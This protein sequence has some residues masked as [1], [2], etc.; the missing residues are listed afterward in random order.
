MS[1]KTTQRCC[2]IGYLVQA[3][4]INFA[5]LLFVIFQNTYGISYALIGLLIFINF[6]TQLAAD[7]FS[8]PMLKFIGYRGSAVIS[9]LLCTAGFILLGI[10]PDVMNPYVGICIATIIYSIGAGLIEVV[11]NPII[12]GLPPECEGS[13]VLTHSFYS[14]GQLGVVLVTTLLLKVFGSNSWRVISAV[15]GIIPFLNGLVFLKTPITPPSENKKREGVQHIF[16]SKTFAAILILMICAGGSEVAMAQWASL[17]AQNALGI[18][19]AL[20]DLLGPCLFAFFMGMG[21][22]IYGI[23]EKR[24]NFRLCS[25]A[26]A[27]LCI[28]CYV[29]AALSKNPYISLAGCSLCGLAISILWPGTVALAANKFPEGDGAMYSAIAVFGDVGCSAAPFI[30]GLIASMKLWGENG[31]RAGLAVNIVYPII[32][33]AIINRLIKKCDA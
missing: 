31:L 7:I 32:F 33:I 30:T 21:R 13:F 23:Y 10:L 3:M 28:L 26:S 20:G 24:M 17:F 6:L 19:K 8:V 27:L 2:Y 29:A 22:L 25:I 9:Q 14:W 4:V 18:D 15:W 5:P 16:K 1:Y 11:I 12:A